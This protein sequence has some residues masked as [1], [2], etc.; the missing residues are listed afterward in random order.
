MKTLRKSVSKVAKPFTKNVRIK[1]IAERGKISPKQ[2]LAR[3][4]AMRKESNAKSLVQKIKKLLDEEMLLDQTLND[5]KPEFRGTQEY[6]KMRQERE[7]AITI[8]LNV[9]KKLET[10]RKEQASHKK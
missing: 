5:S 3:A 10:I 6:T 4:I 7:R 1:K 8:R 2:V 9:M